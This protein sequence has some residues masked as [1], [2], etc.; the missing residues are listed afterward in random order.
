MFYMASSL[1]F[2][3]GWII[4]LSR[5]VF[6]MMASETIVRPVIHRKWGFP[7]AVRELMCLSVFFSIPLVFPNVMERPNDNAA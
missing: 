1:S 6:C 4:N 3:L 2:G 5:S 7:P